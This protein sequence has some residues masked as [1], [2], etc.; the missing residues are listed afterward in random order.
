MLALNRCIEMWDHRIAEKLFER[1]KV[2][3]WIGGALLYGIGLGLGTIPPVPNG[4]L[5]G[6]F[7]NP[8]ILY[9]E[10]KEGVVGC[11]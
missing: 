9:A 10:D 11:R 3:Y 7:W 6:W 5:V 2:N 1:H 8:H 4:M